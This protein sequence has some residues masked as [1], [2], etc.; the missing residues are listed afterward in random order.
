M[1]VVVGVCLSFRERDEAFRKLERNRKIRQQHMK[2]TSLEGS[3]EFDLDWL[4]QQPSSGGLSRASTPHGVDEGRSKS[5]SNESRKGL[6]AAFM[7]TLFGSSQK[8]SP[9]EQEVR[10][11]D[12]KSVTGDILQVGV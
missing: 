5:G 10:S 7:G 1:L 6:V 9:Y 11:T 4:E 8:S 2:E 3:Y 12:S